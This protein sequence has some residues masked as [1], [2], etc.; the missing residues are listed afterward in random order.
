MDGTSVS[1]VAVAH[2]MTVAQLHAMEGTDDGRRW[3]LID[4]ELFVSPAPRFGHQEVI[5]KLYVAL[6][7]AAAP[8]RVP[9]SPVDVRVGART[10]VQ[11]DLVVYSVADSQRLGPESGAPDGV[12]PE[13]AIEVSSPSTRR[14]DLVHKRRLFERAGVREYWFVDRQ[15]GVVDVYEFGVEDDLRT[16]A[17]DAPVPSRL[18]TLD[19]AVAA[20]LAW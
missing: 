3:E 19:V 1:D 10:V 20:L 4:G 13:I 7:D 15:A 5:G 16:T 9:M 12:L 14:L 6:R 17:E 18:V 11:P 2:G 8:R